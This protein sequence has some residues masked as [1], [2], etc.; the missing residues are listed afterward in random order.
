MAKTNKEIIDANI[1]LLQ[2]CIQ[3]QFNK[4]PCKEWQKDFLSDLYLILLDYDN[5]KLNNAYE[6][7]HLNALITR[8]TINQLHSPRSDFYKA[9]RKFLANKDDINDLVKGEDTDDGYGLR[10]DEYVD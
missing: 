3:Y 1:P 5:D 8:I 9:Y 6:N 2:K 4:A 7:G 10:E